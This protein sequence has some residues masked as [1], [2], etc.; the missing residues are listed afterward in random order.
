MRSF[1]VVITGTSPDHAVAQECAAA[2]TDRLRANKIDAQTYSLWGDMDLRLGWLRDFRPGGPLG[3]TMPQLPGQGQPD[4]YLY[5]DSFLFA[6]WGEADEK[7]GLEGMLSDGAATF[8][9]AGSRGVV[10]VHAVPIYGA[11]S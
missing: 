8:I 7:A 10:N 5:H 1:I 9:Q 3:S 4:P 6:W 2:L 11:R